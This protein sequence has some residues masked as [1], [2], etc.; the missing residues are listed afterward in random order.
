MK[1]DAI[2]NTANPKPHI[3]RGTDSAFYA[4]GEEQ[5]PVRRKEIGEIA[6]GQAASTDAFLL[7]APNL[8]PCRTKGIYAVYEINRCLCIVRSQ[9]ARQRRTKKPPDRLL[10]PSFICDL[11]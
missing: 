1:A 11:K 8:R 3:G 10:C 9:G 7:D 6:P 5:L 2:V 4:A